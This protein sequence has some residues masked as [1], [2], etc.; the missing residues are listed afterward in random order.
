MPSAAPSA[1]ETSEETAPSA[2]PSESKGEGGGGG[3]DGDDDDEDEAAMFAGTDATVLISIIIVLVVCLT[4]LCVTRKRD[5]R[6]QALVTPDDEVQ[7]LRDRLDAAHARLEDTERR[8]A[9]SAA[10]ASG[11]STSQ[12]TQR[13][14]MQR[15]DTMRKEDKKDKAQV[16][17]DDFRAKL[18]DKQR[19]GS[20]SKQ[21]VSA[22]RSRARMKREPV[23]ILQRTFV[24]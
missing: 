16:R 9:A 18:I 4:V 19:R 15:H 17:E 13:K 20:R 23:M 5:K 21:Q 11:P 12:A 24:D 1:E 2:A 22:R 14:T 3:G 6:Q 8:L 7:V 10:N